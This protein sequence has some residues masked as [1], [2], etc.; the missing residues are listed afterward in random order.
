MWV[1]R[2]RY[3]C[4]VSDSLTFF[5][6]LIGRSFRKTAAYFQYQNERCLP[7]LYCGNKRKSRFSISVLTLVGRGCS[8]RKL[9]Y[10]AVE[11]EG[12]IRLRFFLFATARFK[13]GTA[14]Q[15]MQC[16][17]TLCNGLTPFVLL[18]YYF[19]KQPHFAPT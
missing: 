1:G 19:T 9:C 11:S 8:R 7:K 14:Y 12:F 3:C 15:A 5:I 10:T 17:T 2:I 13:P 18:A 16:Y 6:T 4:S